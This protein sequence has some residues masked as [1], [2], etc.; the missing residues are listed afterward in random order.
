MIDLEALKEQLEE[1]SK[2]CDFYKKQGY[3][4]GKIKYS[5][6]DR[7]F[8]IANELISELEEARKQLNAAKDEIAKLREERKKAVEEINQ[9]NK[10][11]ENKNEEV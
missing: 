2:V 7:Y 6:T 5:D 1:C 10:K 8:K 4:Q 3:Y 9:L 11:L